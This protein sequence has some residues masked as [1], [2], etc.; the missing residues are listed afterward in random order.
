VF[1]L[2]THFVSMMQALHHMAYKF[3]DKFTCFTEEGMVLAINI[4]SSGLFSVKHYIV[5]GQPDERDIA[6]LIR[7]RREITISSVRAIANDVKKRMLKQD[8]ESDA[9][10]HGGSG[11]A[12]A[13]PV[14]EGVDIGI[15]ASLHHDVPLFSG[16]L[17]SSN[18]NS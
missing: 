18:H 11:G 1:G 6:D 17:V 14:P 12:A 10:H 2:N 3:D 4:C 16:M 13:E 5:Q 9:P 15:G 8:Q 7:T